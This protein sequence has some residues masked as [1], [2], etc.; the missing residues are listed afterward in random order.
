MT[1]KHLTGAASDC[2]VDWHGIDWVSAHQATRRLQ[3]RI[4]KAAK[5]R[6]WGKVKALQRLLTCSLYGKSIAVKRVIE[7][8]GRVTAGVDRK[9]WST[10]TDKAKAILSLKRRG[11]Q[12]QPLRRVF[13]PKTDGKKR[14]LGIPTPPAN[15]TFTQTT[16]GIG[17]SRSPVSPF[18]WSAIYRFKNA[19]RFWR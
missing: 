7:N 19:A 17:G 12:P 6:R 16:F 18:A 15:C 4:A 5:E 8:R 10:P 2:T 11:Y 3:M 9:T 1:V 14:P 13:I